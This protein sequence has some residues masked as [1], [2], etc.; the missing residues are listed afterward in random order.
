M[1]DLWSFVTE[2]I[3]L[4]LVLAYKYKYSCCTHNVSAKLLCQLSLLKDCVR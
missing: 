2:I 3:V 4:D 1:V